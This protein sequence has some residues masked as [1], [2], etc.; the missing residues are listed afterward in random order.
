MSLCKLCGEEK[1]LV[2]AHI[3]PKAFFEPGRGDLAMMFDREDTHPR[4][5]PQGEYD[6]DILCAECEDMFKGWDDYAFKLLIERAVE[7]KKLS[8]AGI[9]YEV[10]ESYDYSKLK[11]FFMSV[12]LRA[13]LSEMDFWQRIS[14]GNR[15][16]TLRKHIMR[17]RAPNPGVFPVFL[18]RLSTSEKYALFYPPE[19]EKRGA[20]IYRFFM[21]RFDFRIRV[22]KGPAPSEI[23]KAVLAPGRPLFILV[24]P[25]AGSEEARVVTKLLQRAKKVYSESIGT[26]VCPGGSHA[27]D[28]G[29]SDGG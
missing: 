9:S 27:R 18:T 13:D 22:D 17:R 4:R 14:L 8:S 26:P 1:K 2:K 23:R 19:V 6:P 16:L 25:T 28:R 24:L 12:L 5:R 10:I 7:R 3:I 11:L 21:G 29:V 15:R 20:V